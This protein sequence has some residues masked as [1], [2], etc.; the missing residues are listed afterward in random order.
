[1]RPKL[2][3]L[4]DGAG[5]SFSVRRD[6]VPYI[7]SD[8]HYHEEIELIHF[9]KGA[10][11]Q[12]VGDSIRDFTQGD[13]VL[14]GS[15]LPHYWRFDDKFFEE[16][17]DVK[18]AHFKQDFWGEQFLDLP[19]NVHIKTV[20]DNSKRGLQILGSAKLRIAQILDELLLEKGAMR[21]V[22]LME[23]LE[24]I[25]CCEK[26]KPL[27]SIGFSNKAPKPEND[28]INVIY[29]FSLQNF[30]RNISIDEI[31]SVAAISPHSFCHFFKSR[32]GKTYSRFLS[33]IRIGHATRLLIEANKTMKQVCYESGFNNSTSF[34]KVFKAITGKSPL[35]YQREYLR[36]S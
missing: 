11:R 4:L 7:N 25:F 6:C 36:H 14:V 1:M 13:V 19:E 2:L 28:R 35:S 20:L 21:I 5:Q 15:N 23:A 8:W 16:G 26:S 30:N 12:F 24:S 10:G 17:I 9:N 3:K 33:E 31:A 32:T 18:V 22:L 27:S 29:N 34:H